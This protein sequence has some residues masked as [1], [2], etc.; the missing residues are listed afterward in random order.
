MGKTLAEKSKTRERGRGNQNG[1]CRA[2]IDQLC[3]QNISYRGTNQRCAVGRVCVKVMLLA[4]SSTPC[5]NA[6]SGVRVIL[7]CIL[8]TRVHWPFSA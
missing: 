4:L 7:V 6:R 2:M 5:I 8:H 1:M 3:S